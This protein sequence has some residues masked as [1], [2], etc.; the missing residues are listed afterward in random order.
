MTL[1]SNI[2]LLSICLAALM[3]GLEISSVPVILPILEAELGATIGDMQWIMSAYTIGCAIVLIISGS[4]ADRYG[5]K[6]VFSAA[7][8]LFG[9]TSLA[10]GLSTGVTALI[11]SRFLQGVAGGAMLTC[12]VTILNVQFPDGPARA[13]AFST[14]GV[15]FGAGLGFGPVVGAVTLEYLDWQWIFLVHAVLSVPTLALV[16][17][18]V[19]ESSD[20]VAKRLDLWGMIALAATIFSA[21]YL[22]QQVQVIGLNSMAGI[23]LAVMTIS[24]I[25]AFGAIEKSVTTPMVDFSVFRARKF[26]G[27]ICGAMGMNMSFWPF[28]IYY[29]LYLEVG[30]CFS[31]L[32]MGMMLM[33]CTVPTI[34]APPLGEK[35]VVR[36][37]VEAVIPAGLFIIGLGFLLFKLGSLVEQPTWL[38]LLPGSII[39]GVGIGITNTPVSN[40]S[41]GSVPPGQAGMASGID[42]SARLV[43]LAIVIAAMGALLVAGIAN[44]LGQGAAHVQQASEALAAGNIAQVVNLLPDLTI[45]AARAA[46]VSGFSWVTVFATVCAWA[47]AVLSCFLFRT[48]STVKA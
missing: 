19:D 14:W 9:L 42:M 48:F 15:V 2:A 6:L 36:F 17:A 7:I 33:A 3:F 8:G 34:L 38:T 16:F 1:S 28:I 24:G 12:L 11:V 40:A 27:A 43:T 5:R 47:F 26:S 41:T 44:A 20:P 23:G 18:S 32:S 13:R 10:C 4:L 45:S 39:A 37:G 29:P 30:L 46:F 31:S 25:I 22:V 35:M 21:T